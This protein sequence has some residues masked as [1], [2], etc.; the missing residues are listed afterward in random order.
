VARV[1]RRESRSV[2]VHV[3]SKVLSETVALAPLSALGVASVPSG[4]EAWIAHRREGDQCLQAGRAV[5]LS[6]TDYLL[7]A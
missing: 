5:Y 7:S 2:H 1:R 3:F 6:T 4:V